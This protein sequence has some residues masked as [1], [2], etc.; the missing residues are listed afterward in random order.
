MYVWM[1]LV[2]MNKCISFEK[3][4][5]KIFFLHFNFS[6]VQFDCDVDDDDDDVATRNTDVATFI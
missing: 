3:K 2:A 6:L 5:L 4:K 1:L